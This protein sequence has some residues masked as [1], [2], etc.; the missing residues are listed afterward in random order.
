MADDPVPVALTPRRSA[1]LGEIIDAHIACE[2]EVV[3]ALEPPAP[4]RDRSAD[5]AVVHQITCARAV[6]AMASGDDPPLC[7]WVRSQNRGMNCV[8]CGRN[9]DRGTER[10]MEL[11]HVLK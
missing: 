6:K 2:D 4:P 9:E 10:H 5:G 1:A 11:N 8:V 7:A 3:A